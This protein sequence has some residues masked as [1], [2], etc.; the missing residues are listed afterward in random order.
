MSNVFIYAQGKGSRWSDSGTKLE[1]PSD[2]K[3]LIPVG[4]VPLIRRTANQFNK[5][6]VIVFGKCGVYGSVFPECVGVWE[7][8]EPTGSI[9]DG[10]LTTAKYWKDD[11][12]SLLV[13]GD[14]IFENKVTQDLSNFS[15]ENVTFFGRLTPNNF[16]GKNVREIFAVALPDDDE[17]KWNFFSLMI[18]LIN[19]FGVE[20]QSKKL[21]DLWDYIVEHGL[22]EYKF[23]DYSILSF[24]DD[25][26]SPEGYHAFGKTLIKL[27]IEDDKHFVL[28]EE[29]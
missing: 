6:H 23:R 22:S 16:T 25:I 17:K 1:L 27:A 15:G 20:R 28:A 13:L 11:G 4:K 10:F 14:V 24:T 19:I 9:I 26:D 18:K 2:Y 12:V 8:K 29:N 5:H 3:Q 21:W 7:L